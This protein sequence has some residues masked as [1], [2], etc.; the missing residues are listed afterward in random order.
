VTAATL[1][2]AVT[3]PPH[4]RPVERMPEATGNTILNIVAVLHIGTVLLRTDSEERRAVI[5]SQS[6]RQVLG[7]SSADRVAIYPAFALAATQPIA[8]AE[9]A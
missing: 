2:I 9:P 7:N 5:H 6:A 3:V 8:Q 4:F 1:A